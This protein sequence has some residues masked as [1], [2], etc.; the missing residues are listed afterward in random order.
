VRAAALDGLKPRPTQDYVNTLMEGFRYPLP[1]VSQRA[2]EALVKLDCKDVLA[3]LVKVLEQPDPRA[4]ATQ[5]IDGKDA[6]VVRELVRVNHHRNCLLCH[7]PANTPDVAADVLTVPVPLPGQSF[8]PSGGYNGP[9]QPS[10]D[11]FVRIDMTY[12][13]QDFSMM[14]RVENAAPWPEMQRFDFLVRTRV[15]TPVQAADCVKELAGKSAPNHTAAQFALRGLT[16]QTPAN[17]TP[18]EWRRLLKL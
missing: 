15:L 12:L 2:A 14:M 11:I 3:D 7:A 13:R 4:P 9:T 16:G 1:A 17:A 5:Q 18:Q 6:A 10:K 8:E